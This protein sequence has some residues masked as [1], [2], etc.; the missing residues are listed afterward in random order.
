MM[1]NKELA[2][3]LISGGFFILLT[4]NNSYG[5]NA[6]CVGRVLLLRPKRKKIM[7]RKPLL[8]GL[9]ALSIISL[10]FAPAAQAA[11]LGDLDFGTVIQIQP[12]DTT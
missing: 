7:S 6:F 3:A 5:Y 2:P 12:T 9:M 8:H 1:D 10:A 11:T 4:Y